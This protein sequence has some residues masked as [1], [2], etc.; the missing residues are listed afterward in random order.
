MPGDFANDTAPKPE[1][2][3]FSP[4]LVPFLGFAGILGLHPKG[5]KV[6]LP[7]GNPSLADCIFRALAASS[8]FFTGPAIKIAEQKTNSVGRAFAAVG[9]KTFFP[10][11]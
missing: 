7:L 4:N 2:F 10:P 3:L 11:P 9:R 1:F 5:A 6:V 8:R